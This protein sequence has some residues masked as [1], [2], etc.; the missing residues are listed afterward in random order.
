MGSSEFSRIC[1][2]L[3]QIAESGTLFPTILILTKSVN[4]ET[5]KE[6]VKF[7][8]VGEI[9]GG[10]ILL[11]PSETEKGGEK[12]T[13]EVE[14]PVSASFALRYLN[15]F[16]KAA[17]LSNQVILSM[18]PETPLVVEFKIEKLGSMKF[19]L[20]PKLNEEAEN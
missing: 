19:Y 6:F 17:C 8:V 7:G 4:I 11:R 15:S 9:G 10:E 14:E 12:T 16:N 5:S 1:K 20:A 13:L 2:E 3:G 18:S